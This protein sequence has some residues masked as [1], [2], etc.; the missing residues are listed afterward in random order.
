VGQSMK[1]FTSVFDA[2]E[3]NFADKVD[4]DKAVY[5]GAIPG[6]LRT[7]D[8]HSNFFDPKD[9]AVLKEEQNGHYSGVGMQVGPRGTKTV[10][11]AP[12]PGSPAYRAG[13]R[14]GDTIV[15]VNEKSTAGLNTTEVADLLKGPRDT[16][17]KIVVQREGS[18]DYITFTVTRED[19]SRKTVQDAFW[20]KPGIAYVKVL[21]FGDYTSRE[22]QQNL[23]RLGENSIQGLVL[24]LRENPGGLLDQAVDICD[25]FLQKG[26]TI[27]SQRG[28]SSAEKVY[29]AHR[30]NQGRDYPIV[31]LVNKFSASAAEIVSGALQD[32]DRAW[33]LGETTFGKGLV[34]TL[35]PLSDH[36]GLA[37][38]TAHF[39]TPSGRLIQ[40]DYSHLSF[41]DYY[42]D[43]GRQSR[44]MN[45]VKMTDGG[46]T[47]Y[48]GGGI[49]PDEAYKAPRL[50]SLEA[51]LFRNG[52]FNF[53]RTYFAQHS[54]TLPKGWMPDNQV[55]EE[56]HDFLLKQ[57]TKFSEAQFTADHEWIKRNLAKEMYI[58]AFNVDESDRVFALTDPEVQKAIDAMPQAS[59]LLQNAK[60]VLVQRMR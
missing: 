2:V 23:R 28:R 46:R 1:S 43:G 59:T 30:G 24:D 58:W 11:V 19:I 60:K 39:Y 26:Q 44:N 7:L 6:M 37:L 21:S 38:T 20:L 41:Y 14:P 16:Q 27:V 9:F 33:I 12:F 57:G 10:I 55:V 47:V 32:H 15:A 25:H 31:V 49:T 45:D 50:D 29:T 35:Y 42:F 54:T 36:T 18:P 17:V 5:N 22:L 8:P 56:L 3:Q 4:A 52:L 13:L 53:S 40:R 34:Q 51:E 48:G